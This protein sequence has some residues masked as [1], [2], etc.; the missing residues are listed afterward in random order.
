MVSYLIHFFPLIYVYIY[1]CIFIIVNI[2]YLFII[3]IIYNF[4]HQNNNLLILE[5]KMHINKCINHIQKRNVI[6]KDIE[7]LSHKINNIILSNTNDIKMLNTKQKIN[8]LEISELFSP[9]MQVSIIMYMLLHI[10]MRS[11]KNKNK[12]LYFSV[13]C[14]DYIKM[15]N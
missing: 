8:H 15:I 1:L 4:S 5:W 12:F 10:L 14:F 7:Q 13:F 3:S 2:I 6:L 11:N 9:D